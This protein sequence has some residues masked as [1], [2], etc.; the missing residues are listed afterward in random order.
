MAEFTDELVEK[1]NETHS[2]VKGIELV[3]KGYNGQKG[4]CERVDVLEDKHRKLVER[5]VLLVGILG[6][7]GVLGSRI[8]GVTVTS[9]I[10]GWGRLKP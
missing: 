10:K 1:I 5:F 6:G 8:W 7:S 2:T 9:R 3:L 4:I